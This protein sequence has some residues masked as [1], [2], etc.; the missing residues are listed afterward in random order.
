M[1]RERRHKSKARRR[2]GRF[3]GLYKLLSVLLVTA[4]I[5]V[6]CVVF[7]RVNR[8]TVDGNHRYTAEEIVAA[9]QIQMGDNL[10]ALSKGRIANRILVGLPYVRSVSIDRVFP[11]GVLLTVEEHLAAAAVYDGGN[12]WYISS[13]GKLLEQSG[14]SGPIRITGITAVEPTPGGTLSVDEDEQSRLYY[15]LELLEVLE[16]REM[17]DDCTA[18]DCKTTGQL[19]LEYLNFVVKMPTT[20]DFSYMLHCLESALD[21]DE[22][23]SREDSGTFDFTVA[24]GKFYF[25]RS[26]ENG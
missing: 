12:W 18:L 26:A 6:A 20:G 22:R 8:V 21:E 14:Q 11:D 2:R 9:S 5:V 16:E 17:L 24:D 25:S 4:A 3:S 23:I 15:V 7:F 10:I 1:A 13:Q 19:R